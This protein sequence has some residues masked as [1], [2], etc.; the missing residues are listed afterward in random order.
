MG[1]DERARE[2]AMAGATCYLCGRS[3]NPDTEECNR[4]HVPPRRI[5]ASA[6]RRQ[7]GPNLPT[8]P[9]HA[10]CNTAAERDEAYFIVSFAGHVDTDVAREVMRDIGAKARQG[11]GRGLLQDVVNRFG[12]VVGPKG[13]VLY[14]YESS[15]TDRFLWKVV[16]GLYMLDTGFVLPEQ[17]PAGIE[18]LSPK[19][20]PGELSKVP[21][22]NAV[23]DTEPLGRYGRVFDY[24]WL[25]WNDGELRGHAVAMLF[26]DGLVA[27][28]MFHDPRC[29]CGKCDDWRADRRAEDGAVGTIDGDKTGS[30]SLDANQQTA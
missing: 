26:W 4:D 27:A 9:T 3:I 17:P 2:K 28:V 20:I 16:R 11:E 25:C 14:S 12:K 1:R 13:E 7:F 18:L 22:F 10:A 19:Q 30:E 24:K 29:R 15:R 5:F 21:W 8:L 23:R 6:V